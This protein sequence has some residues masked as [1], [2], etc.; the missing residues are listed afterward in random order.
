MDDKQRQAVEEAFRARIR[1]V[2]EEVLTEARKGQPRSLTEIEELALA[3]RAKIGQE[4]TQHLVEE[5]AAVAAPGARCPECGGEMHFKGRKKRRVV[6]RSGEVTW[7]RGH[8]Y[9]A[10]CRRGFFPPG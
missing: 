8:Y 5:Q 6:S 4:I 3:A 1:G 10:R 7:E 2:V 9:C